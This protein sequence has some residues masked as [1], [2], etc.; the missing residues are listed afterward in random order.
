LKIVTTILSFFYTVY[1]IRVRKPQEYRPG[2]IDAMRPVM[3]AKRSSDNLKIFC[4]A[5]VPGT[6][7]LRVMGLI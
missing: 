4:I 6:R 3:F 5:I 7:K 2:E 1:S